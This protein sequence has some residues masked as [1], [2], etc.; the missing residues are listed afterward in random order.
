MIKPHLMIQ[1][2]AIIKY[3]QKNLD[4]SKLNGNEEFK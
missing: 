1:T 2:K 3:F 4:H